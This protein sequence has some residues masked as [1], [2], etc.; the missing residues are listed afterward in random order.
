[1]EMSE[2]QKIVAR[3]ID[4][5]NKNK[6]K[7]KALSPEHKKKI[8]E[9]L[10]KNPDFYK[11][12]LGRKQSPEVI[13]KRMA[14]NKDWLENRGGHKI[15]SDAQKTKVWAEGAKEQWK[16]NVG[17]ANKIAYSKPGPR[18]KLADAIRGHPNYCPVMPETGKQKIREHQMGSNNSGWN[19][20]S[21]NLPYPFKFNGTLK[22][23]IKLRDHF[24]C[25]LCGKYTDHKGK[26][27]QIHHVDYIKENCQDDNLIS[28]CNTCNSH[29]N[30]KRSYW[31]RYFSR[32][33]Q[34]YYYSG[35][36]SDTESENLCLTAITK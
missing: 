7:R 14:R 1:M 35:Y 24:E 5:W 3:L 31:Q 18:E 21:S 25:Q 20:G 23:R 22:E 8:S 33:L 16:K 10:L 36:K 13:L 2:E 17:A 27:L 28:L 34:N 4:F 11:V 6:K 26:Y 30:G 12:N 9:S 19:G 29:V 15:L 32:I